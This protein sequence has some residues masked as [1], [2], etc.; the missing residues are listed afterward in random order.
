MKAT[1]LGV[2]T[3][4]VCVL[5]LGGCT[6]QPHVYEQVFDRYYTTTLKSSTSAD[7]LASIQDPETELLSQSE[8]VVAAWG[9]EGEEKKPSR[10]HWFNMVAFDEEQMNAVRKCGFILEETHWGWN[11]KPRPALRFD[12]EMVMAPDVLDAAYANNNEKQIAVIKKTQDLFGSDTQELT[13]DS[14]S[15]H[16]STIM[17][18][19]AFNSVLYKLSHSPAYAV[20][21][22]QPEGM[23]FDHPTLGESRIRM[24]I[25]GDIVKIKIKAGKP[26]FDHYYIDDPFQEQPDVKYM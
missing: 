4:G 3:A 17:V 22:P 19:Q 26:W 25:E 12:T 8:S 21:L 23:E 7:V 2:I 14:Q 9:K 5:F 13:F 20:K 15:F 10:T 11:Q 16:S 18:Q 24:L 1:V 6:T